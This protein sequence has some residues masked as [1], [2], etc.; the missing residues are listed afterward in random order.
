MSRPEKSKQITRK[1]PLHQTDKS[2]KNGGSKKSYIWKSIMKPVS[3][4]F[5]NLESTHS[6]HRSVLPFLTFMVDLA[7]AKIL[8]IREE[9]QWLNYLYSY[10]SSRAKGSISVNTQ[11]NAL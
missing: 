7:F 8:N 5:R 3:F 2:E 6:L 9:S 10:Y 4:Y 1:M 11:T